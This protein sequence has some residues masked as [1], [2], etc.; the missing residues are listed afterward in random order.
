MLVPVFVHPRLTIIVRR[1]VRLL[2]PFY[3]EPRFWY[4]RSRGIRV[5]SGLCRRLTILLVQFGKHLYRSGWEQ[6]AE[7]EQGVYKSRGCKKRARMWVSP[8][9]GTKKQGWVCS[10]RYVPKYTGGTVFA[11]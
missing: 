10:V 3:G 8:T 9:L 4:I 2:W 11:R 5:L 1:L 7:R 6:C